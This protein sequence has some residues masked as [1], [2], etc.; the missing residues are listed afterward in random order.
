MVKRII[1]CDETNYSLQK[2]ELKDKQDDKTPAFLEKAS[3]REDVE[4]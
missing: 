1:V 4:C 3:E 2:K